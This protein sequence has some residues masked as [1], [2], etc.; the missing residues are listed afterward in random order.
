[1]ARNISRRGFLKGLAAAAGVA[2]IPVLANID[3]LAF[4]WGPA[5][6]YADEVFN[7][8][9]QRGSLKSRFAVI[10]DTHVTADNATYVNNLKQAFADLASIA[11][12]PE[13]IVVNGD[14]VNDG[15]TEEYDLFMSL[16][17]SAGIK[18]SSLKMVM[19]NH[20][21]STDDDGNELYEQ[22]RATFMQYAG[23]SSVY[24]DTE[25]SSLHLIVVGPDSNPT[26]DWVNFKLSTDQLLWLDDLLQKDED[27]GVV[28]YVFCHEP[29]QN[30]VK[31]T[32]ITQWGYN[33]SIEND[34]ALAQVIDAHKN[35]VL[36]SGHTHAYPDVARSAEG[37]LYV[38]TGSVAYAYPKGSSDT[39]ASEA[40]ESNGLMVS[41]YE[42]CI[43]IQVRDF[44][45]GSWSDDLFYALPT[46]N[47]SSK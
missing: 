47:A 23:T 5:P 1:M 39:D 46:T 6:A 11:D 21:Q 32:R 30:T 33:N 12:Q 28:S 14:L 19:G 38:G 36:F 25:V 44:I 42:R 22:R 16:A 17:A 10:S 3:P 43:R 20:E 18:R 29:L 37:R 8:P 35:T 27:R 45:T 2:T 9:S 4:G 13:Y 40:V 41:V 7:D 34:S 26:N 15:T 31:D 24:Y